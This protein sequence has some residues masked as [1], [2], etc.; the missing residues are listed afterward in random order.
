MT[1]AP[2]LACTGCGAA[3]SG[4]LPF[5]CPHAGADGGDHVLARPAPP[6]ESR[7]SSEGD[8]NPFVRYRELSF[9]WSVAC[10]RG[11][12]DAEYVDLVRGLDRAVASVDGH[13]FA[14]TPYGTAPK[15][16]KLLGLADRGLW[17]KDETGNEIGRAHV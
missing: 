15:V 16:A 10:S 9:A 6:S 5:R 13:G 1:P 7:V 12:A 11:L 8:P 17:I 3:V 14:I 4:A 2:F